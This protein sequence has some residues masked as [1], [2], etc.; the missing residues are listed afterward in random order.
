MNCCMKILKL[1]YK[2]SKN[3][4]KNKFN[5]L[6]RYDL[7]GYFRIYSN[8]FPNGIVEISSDSKRIQFNKRIVSRLNCCVSYPQWLGFDELNLKNRGHVQ[9]PDCGPFFFTIK[10][11]ITLPYYWPDTNICNKRMKAYKMIIILFAIHSG[12]WWQ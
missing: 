5:C 9:R 6:F 7:I 3:N 10:I 12:W 11:Y 1:I 4:Y 2:A 8:E